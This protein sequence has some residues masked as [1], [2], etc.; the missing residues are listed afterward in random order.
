M[1]CTASVAALQVV[2][3]ASLTRRTVGL[4]RLYACSVGGVDR[5]TT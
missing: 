5:S 2:D 3:I 4:R 1:L